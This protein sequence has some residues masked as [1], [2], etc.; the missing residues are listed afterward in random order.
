MEREL[1]QKTMRGRE[2]ELPLGMPI[3]LPVQSRLRD[4]AREVDRA[5]LLTTDTGFRWKLEAF[6]CM[7][8][9]AVCLDIIVRE[10][11]RYGEKMTVITVYPG[12][13]SRDRP[14]AYLKVREV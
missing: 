8:S 11:P 3:C 14:T 5:A 12:W 2:K 10:Q 6:N 7:G 9:G 4:Q 13:W 1:E